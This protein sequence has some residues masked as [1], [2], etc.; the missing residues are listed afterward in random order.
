MF[1]NVENYRVVNTSTDALKQH[2]PIYWNIIGKEFEELESL[3]PQNIL[4]KEI[5]KNWLEKFSKEDR[6]EIVNGFFQ[7]FK[8]ANIEKYDDFQNLNLSM[9]TE[10]LKAK[11]NISPK[12]KEIVFE[13]VKFFLSSIKNSK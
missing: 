9:I 1:E 12:T 10:L 8:E 6:K 3:L 5:F 13:I 2:D 7:V 11:S 4:L